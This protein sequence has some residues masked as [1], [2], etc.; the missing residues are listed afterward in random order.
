MDVLMQITD[1]RGLLFLGT[2]VMA[3]GFLLTMHG[4]AAY[5]LLLWQW[6]AGAATW[7]YIDPILGAFF[8]GAG[9]L[10]FPIATHIW[11]DPVREFIREVRSG[12]F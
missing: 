4:A 7:V 11:G 10:Q 8:F 3:A 6:S 5:A 9:A 2:V 1:F 12:P